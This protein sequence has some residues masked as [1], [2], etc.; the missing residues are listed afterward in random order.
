MIRMMAARGK[1]SMLPCPPGVK[2]KAKCAVPRSSMVVP[3]DR[4][5]IDSYLD[6]LSLEVISLY[7]FERVRQNSISFLRQSKGDQTIR[8]ASLDAES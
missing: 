1:R 8:R 2:G 3:L 5:N 7:P 6:L 4:E